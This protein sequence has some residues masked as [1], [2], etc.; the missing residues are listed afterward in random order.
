MSASHLKQLSINV[1]R[2]STTPF[3]L[4]FDKGKKLTVIYGENGSGKT[5]ICD[6]FEFIGKGKVGS[7]DNRGLGSTSRYWPSVG[8]NASEVS[9]VLKCTDAECSA[10]LQKTGVVVLP[11]EARPKVEVLRRSQ[12]LSLVE[13]KP[14]E[15][16]EAISRFIDV[17]GI[18]ASETALRNLIRSL[19]ES[20]G[21]AVAR[22]EE[23]RETIFQFWETAGKPD[24]DPVTWATKESTRDMKNLQ[25]EIAAI[26]KL[27]VAYQRLLDCPDK[28]DQAST[29]LQSAIEVAANAMARLQA[30]LQNV[31][32]N[33]GELVGL[34][35]SAQAY[36]EKHPHLDSCPLCESSDSVR[37]LFGRVTSRLQGLTELQVAQRVSREADAAVSAAEKK[38]QEVKD[39]VARQLAGFH[40]A[41]EAYSWPSGFPL[42]DT[43]E[44]SNLDDLAGWLSSTDQLPDAWEKLENSRRDNQRFFDVLK[45]ALETY[46]T[47]YTAQKELDA[48]L[49]R[50]DRA[51]ASVEEERHKFT[52]GVL[53]TIASEVGRLY[54]E[55]HPGE[56]LEMI[57]LDLDPKKR[58]SLEI[59]SHF[60]GQSDTPP[61]AYFS[62]S[63]LDTLG[64]CV[65]LALS[66]MEDASEIV[67]VLDDVLASVD[68][69]HV[70]RLI[71]MVYAEAMKFRHCVITTHY[72]PWKEK[73]RW[74]WL[75]N[76]QCQF[77]ELTKWTFND[78]LSLTKSIPD[79]ERL[80]ML[81]AETPPDPQLV[82]AK[83]G[84]ILEAALDFLTQL[85]ECA[86][87]RRPGGR[88][89]LG[90]LLP[91]IDR[92]L[93]QA[94]KVEVL[95]SGATGSAPNYETV[96]LTPIIEELTRIVQARNLFGCHFNALSFEL[97]ES[98]AIGFGREVLALMD[99]LI[100]PEAGWPRNK[101]SGS[102]WATSGETRRLYPLQQP[103]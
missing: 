88:Y 102:Y 11:P 68:E 64:L 29:A 51:L 76:G 43:T 1:L 74:G 24:R 8:R 100:D 66:A 65:F 101:K 40:S 69:P 97:L 14:A 39:D 60:Y 71:E 23:N 7:L 82:C 80:R 54:E 16:Y 98:D 37:D 90:D 44:P 10:Y 18:E 33:A 2:G 84:V 61:Q 94:L 27:R 17:S 25:T 75:Q 3:T 47:N 48:L 20:R 4:Q 73:L 32:A 83:A 53:A 36:I 31:A 5:T 67:L 92:K 81:L 58:A 12:I 41:R 15:R 19:K 49:P 85:Y 13:A 70:D 30:V 45:S 103:S 72:R 34:L 99:V 42:P 91:S 86:V 6:A 28:Y 77:V 89:T 50:L 55:V 9:V 95:K 46:N 59:G 22:V 63:H 93:R 57:S 62:Q 87:P 96:S 52:T 78:G 79:V 38:L 35:Q 26:A 56:G 21:E